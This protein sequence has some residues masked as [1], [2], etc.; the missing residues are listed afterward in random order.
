LWDS[1]LR[2]GLQGFWFPQIGFLT[3]DSFFGDSGA[4]LAV[5]GGAG[6]RS[7]MIPQWQ[8]NGIK[9]LQPEA[10]KRTKRMDLA[11]AMGSAFRSK[12]GGN[13]ARCPPRTVA[14]GD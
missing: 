13:E 11:G 4:K 12:L 6:E 5:Y 14:S 3:R 10:G 8:A 2:E 7:G 9:S 1:R